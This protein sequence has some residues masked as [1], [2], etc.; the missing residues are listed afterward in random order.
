VVINQRHG[1]E[2]GFTLAERPTGLGDKG[3]LRLE[4]AIEGTLRGELSPDGQTVV[5]RDGSGGEWM[6]YSGL[7]AW[8]AR[9]QELGAKLEASDGVIALVV[10]ASQAVYPVTIDPLITL[11][12]TRRL[13][14]LAVG[15]HDFGYSVSISGDTLVVGAPA[16][17]S[18]TGAAYVFERNQGGTNNWGQVKELAASDA[19]AGDAFGG[20]VSISEDTVVVGAYGS[21]NSTGAAYVFERNQGGTNN[22]GQVQELAASDVATGDLFGGSVS[23]SG[24]TVVVGAYQKKKILFP[25]VGAAYVF[26]RNQG[27]ANNWG[28]VQKLA[29]SDAAAGDQFGYS[30]SISTNTVVVGAF[31]KSFNIGVAYVF[32]RNQ[33]GPNNWGQVQKLAASDAAVGDW[34]G[35]SVSISGDTLVVGAFTKYNSIGAAYVFDRNQGGA[36]NWGQVKELIASD[37]AAD[38]RFGFSVSISGDTVVVGAYLKNSGTGAAYVFERNQGGA[39]NWGEVQELAASD[40]AANDQFGAS[41]SISGDTVVV[42]A[43]QKTNSAGVFRAGA[44][45]VFERNQGGT[46]NWGQV[47]KLTVSDAAELDFFGEHVSIST[48]TVVVGAR[49]KNSD[50]G[51]AYVFERNQGGANN[52][53]QVQELAASDAA[54][55]D[56]FG[57]SVSI[58]GDTVV[59][60]AIG[61]NINTGAAYVF[62]RNQGGANNWG[63]VQELVATNAADGDVFG[64]SVSISGDTVVVGASRKNSSAGDFRAGAAYVFERNQGGSNNW[65]QV[66]QLAASDTA[67]GDE[68]G[69]SVSISGDT[70]VV[71]AYLKTNRTGAAYV[72]ERNQG[73]TNN[74]VQVKE[75]IASDGAAGDLFGHE[76]SISGDTVVVGA[77]AKNSETGAAYAFERNQG[78]SNNWGQVQKLA[79]SD[80][81]VGDWFGYSVSIS[82]DKVVVGANGK[83][84]FA[85]AAY[86]FD[87]PAP[88]ITTCKLV[89]PSNIIDVCTESGTSGAT[90]SY[91]APT[92]TGDCDGV[93][94]ACTPASGSWF[95]VGSTTVNCTANDERGQTVDQCSFTVTVKDCQAPTI[96]CPD[97]TQCSEAGIC[98]AHVSFSPTVTDNCPGTVTTSFTPASGSLF[99]VGTTAV[100]CTATDTSGNSTSCTFKVIVTFCSTKCPLSSGFW[101]N[102][103]SLWPVPSLTLGTVNYN[104]A[105]LLAILNLSTGSGNKADASLI[106]A[107]QLIAAKLNLANGA[108]SCPIASTVAAADALIG[109]RHIP[110][111]PKITPATAVGNQMVSLAGPLGQYNTGLLTPGCTP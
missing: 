111:V 57:W 36:N 95:P 1:V 25:Q 76:V 29:A 32:D 58:S 59:V 19:A 77:W 28:Q 8:D 80:A 12:E 70:V 48:N 4:L 52:W 81:A 100:K 71:G 2:Q 69:F 64:G 99:P 102:H 74:W 37:A 51:A 30:V 87:L 18:S 6:R 34:F 35:Y 73:G 83:N 106:L 90:V 88:T 17:N 14:P 11:T 50:A 107:Q 92:M 96:N 31:A 53:G 13:A 56:Y 86:V 103:A 55:Y 44:A 104:Q 5:L 15:V 54:A 60:G 27:G 75:L 84:S 9:H 3:P 43:Y 20:S 46:N 108:S 41:V 38:D 85:G 24:D 68:F 66:Q 109:A 78:G 10:E 89:C 82:G 91:S 7:K 26:D 101:K 39:N 94:V 22:W 61:K 65:G 72:I 98:G 49:G 45:Y 23:I 105:Q 40:A 97:V 79:A 63:Q 62:E 47:Q 93:M 16:K 67:A 33:G 21:T 110:I 42:G